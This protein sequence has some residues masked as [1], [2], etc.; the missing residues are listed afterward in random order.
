MKCVAKLL[1]NHHFQTG[2][3]VPLPEIAHFGWFS[4]TN[5]RWYFCSIYFM[6]FRWPLCLDYLILCQLSPTNCHLERLLALYDRPKGSLTETK[7][8][9]SL[10]DHLM[11]G[12]VFRSFKL[13]VHCIEQTAVVSPTVNWIALSLSTKKKNDN[14]ENCSS[15]WNR[16][17]ISFCLVNIYALSINW[18]LCESYN[19]LMFRTKIERQ[20][21]L[22]CI[23]ENF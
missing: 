10:A 20:I 6:I 14:V 9:L 7:Y 4:K 21:E 13:S 23:F 16:L 8:E 17:W 3:T 18:G 2:I 19:Q 15:V 1:G 22:R 11:D 5:S 12:Y